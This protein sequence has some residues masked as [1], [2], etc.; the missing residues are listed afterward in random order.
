MTRRDEATACTCEDVDFG[1][2][3]AA[4]CVVLP[5]EARVGNQMVATIDVCILP[6]I[7]ALWDRGIPTVASCCGH[8]RIAG[9]II[10]PEEYAGRMDALGYRRDRRQDSLPDGAF[11]SKTCPGP[12]RDARFAENANLPALRDHPTPWTAWEDSVADAAGVT[13]ALVE[14]EKPADDAAATMAPIDSRGLARLI[15]YAV[16]G[17]ARPKED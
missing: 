4:V 10:V 14:R 11:V 17:L 3:E 9:S 13:I 8:N 6:E 12:E 16:N 15:A 2:Y 1:T 7:K 5:C